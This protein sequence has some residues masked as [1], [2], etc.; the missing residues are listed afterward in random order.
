MPMVEMDLLNTKGI[1]V[2]PQRIAVYKVLKEKCHAT[3]EEIYE[4]IKREFPMMSFATVYSILELFKEKGL[5]NELKIDFVK[6]TFDI[7]TD[8][9]HHFMCKKCG[10]I[11]DVDIS[12]CE[13]LKKGKVNGHKI[14]S[15]QGYFYGICKKCNMKMQKSNIKMQ[16]GK[17]KF[18]KD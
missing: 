16:N 8:G 2:T 17:E 11:Y 9:H 12:P 6:S 5:A 10:R 14:E 7:R 13:I 4:E 1:R 15:F 3:A 18:K